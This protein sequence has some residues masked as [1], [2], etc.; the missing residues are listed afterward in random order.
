MIALRLG[1][2]AVSVLAVFLPAGLLAAQA[3]TASTTSAQSAVLCFPENAQ[4]GVANPE[5]LS[6]TRGADLHPYLEN[7]VLPLIRA[8]WF[9][10][11]SKS[12]E[13][14]GGDATLQFTIYKDGSVA[15]VQVIDGTGHAALGGLAV[16]SVMKSA[17]FASLP[18]EFP[19]QALDVRMKL[20]YAPVAPQFGSSGA[21]GMTLTCSEDQIT[22]GAQDCIMPPH[23]I[24]SPEPD[25]TQEARKNKTQ[26]TV[27]LYVVV[28]AD[29]TVLNA[30]AAQRLGDGLEESA[31]ETIRK[32][33]FEPATR[34]G[35]ATEIRIAI[36]VD[37]H[38]EKNPP[39]A[40]YDPSKDP[41]VQNSLNSSGSSV[42]VKVLSEAT[43]SAANAG[44]RPGLVKTCG[45]EAAGCVRPPRVIFSSPPE[46]EATKQ[47]GTTKYSGTAILEL[48]VATDGTAQDIKIIRGLGPDLDQKAINAVKKWKFEPATKDGKPV[49]VQIRV[50]VDFHLQ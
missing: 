19:G 30:C 24:F 34:N 47:A 13:K 31:V 21:R 35:K 17:P 25:L 32:W 36:E 27:M 26:G 39:A 16:N 18:A 22:K 9:Q 1:V 23:V 7:S 42:G 41:A 38:L 28:G 50:E 3:S 33:K 14:T 10:L 40:P 6:D 48:V 44:E 12:G 8:N 20:S 5:V 37:F 49:A 2:W 11:I 29:G 46:Q 4:T 45:T 15:A 43:A